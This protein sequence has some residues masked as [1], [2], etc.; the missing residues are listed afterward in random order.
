[1]CFSIQKGM[2]AS[3]S[4]IKRFKHNDMEDLERLLREQQ[5]EDKKVVR[6]KFVYFCLSVCPSVCLSVSLY[7]SRYFSLL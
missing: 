1:M 2:Q 7:S 5:E 3:R 4:T 6:S